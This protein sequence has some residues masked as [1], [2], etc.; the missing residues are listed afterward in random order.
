MQQLDFGTTRLLINIMHTCA[1]RQADESHDRCSQMAGRTTRAMKMT[2]A[3][4]VATYY[5]RLKMLKVAEFGGKY[6]V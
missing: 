1:N 5:M 3:R 4:D 2:Y 6:W